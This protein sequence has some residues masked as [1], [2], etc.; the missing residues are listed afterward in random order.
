MCPVAGTRAVVERLI[1]P[2]AQLGTS[3]TSDMS[4]KNMFLF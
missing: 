1:L 3:K 2:T 4:V